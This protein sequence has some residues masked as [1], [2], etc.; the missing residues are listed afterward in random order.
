MKQTAAELSWRCTSVMDL[1]WQVVPGLQLKTPCRNWYGRK[2]ILLGGNRF[3]NNCYNQN[4]TKD[5]TVMWPYSHFHLYRAQACQHQQSSPKFLP[6]T[7][8]THN[9]SLIPPTQRTSQAKTPAGYSTVLKNR[10]R[11]APS[12]FAAKQIT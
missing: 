1:H 3:Q 7:V 10:L 4:P 9:S 5:F 6:V 12:L 8:Q 11:F 2:P